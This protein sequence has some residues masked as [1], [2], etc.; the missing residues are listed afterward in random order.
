MQDI[1]VAKHRL[2]LRALPI[3]LGRRTFNRIRVG[4]FDRHSRPLIGL[5]DD[6]GHGSVRMGMIQCGDEALRDAAVQ[7]IRGCNPGAIEAIGKMR[8]NDLGRQSFCSLLAEQEQYMSEGAAFVAACNILGIDQA[9]GHALLQQA[10]G[11]R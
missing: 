10:G 5:A 3:W 11:A 6:H 9:E 2:S 7:I 1:F 4:M 8:S